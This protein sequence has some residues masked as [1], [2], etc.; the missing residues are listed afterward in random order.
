MSKLEMIAAEAG[1]SKHTVARVLNGKTKEVW[2]ST[3]KRADHIRK[4]AAKHGYRTNAAASAIRTKR[5]NANGLLLS[6][7]MHKATIH[8]HTQAA[9]LKAHH[10]LDKHLIV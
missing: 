2:P 3:I 4:L 5:F 1:V 10:E 6:T 9:L 7:T 8:W